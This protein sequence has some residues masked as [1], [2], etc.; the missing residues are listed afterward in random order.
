M[1]GQHAV[2]RVA[3][4]SM[5]PRVDGNEH[6]DLQ[7]PSYGIRRIQAAVLACPELA[8]LET[9]LI[10]LTVADCRDYVNELESFEPQ[11]IGFSLFVWSMPVLTQVAQEIRRRLPQCV[12]VFGGPSARPEVFDL[13]WYRPRR[14]TVDAL[15]TREGEVTFCDLVRALDQ[16]ARTLSIRECLQQ[17]TGLHLPA[18]D[19]WLSTGA[20]KLVRV[21]DHLASPYQ[22]GL[23]QYGDVGYLET[24]RGCPMSCTF[25]EWGAAD[26]SRGSFS[27]KYLIRELEGLRNHGC[28]SVFNVDAGLNLNKQAFRNLAAAEAK[29]Q[30]FRESRIWCEIYP[31]MIRDEHLDFLSHCGPS[32]LGVGLQSFDP[33]LLQ[34]LKRPTGLNEF[35]DSI[36][37]LAAV[38]TNLEVQVIF[39]LPTDSWSGF[40]ETLTRAI[41]LPATVRVYH[42][43]VLPD[44]LLTRGDPEWQM[45]FDERSLAMISCAGWSAD[46]ILEMRSLLD[47]E[48]LGC[49]GKAGKYWWSFPPPAARLR[50]PKFPERYFHAAPLRQ[51]HPQ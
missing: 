43:L 30:L 51:D 38:A 2:R 15:V 4:V 10:D 24:F 45:Q 36:Q 14:E 13:A 12:L 5:T 19:H 31:S 40:M 39:G 49:G 1:S 33:Q 46:Q 50:D 22:M 35:S 41:A 21:L 18:A 3:L 23:M 25:C 9:R 8:H 34:R 20:R 29:V 44:A 47:H 26:L 11:V 27:E 42:A 7:L 37:K 32:Y 16:R 28:D 17:V 6:G 48:S